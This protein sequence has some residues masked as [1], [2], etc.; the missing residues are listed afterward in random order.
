MTTTASNLPAKTRRGELVYE[1]NPF[2]GAAKANTRRGV[3]KISSGNKMMVVAEDTG[4]VMGGAGFWQTQEVDKTQFV[5]L[6]INGVKAFA[7]LSAA[8]AKVFA[9]LYLEMQKRVGQDQVFLSYAMIDTAIF[10]D[11]SES[12]YTR[13]IKDL[14]EKNF[15]AASTVQGW[16]FV[17]PDFM[18]NGD[19][20]AFVKEYRLKPEPKRVGKR[21]TGTPDMFAAESA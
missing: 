4:E 14:K 8:G 6:Y 9:V 13:G 19:R 21:D 7:G 5:K 11:L 15:I 12:T 1:T 20:L 18:W 10:T 16:F 2:L 17:N 3:K